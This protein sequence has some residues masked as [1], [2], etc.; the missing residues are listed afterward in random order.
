M[1]GAADEGTALDL[2]ATLAGGRDAAPTVALQAA[3][4]CLIEE[5]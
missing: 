2:V 4:R 5:H 3:A 1:R